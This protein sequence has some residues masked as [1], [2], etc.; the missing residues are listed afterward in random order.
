MLSNYLI[1]III[2][3]A[4]GILIIVVFFYLMITEKRNF[5][6]SLLAIDESYKVFQLQIK[7]DT[8]KELEKI[9]EL[10]YRLDHSRNNL[11][12]GLQIEIEEINQSLTNFYT[13][14]KE[15][16]E[17]VN[18]N[19]N[20]NLNLISNIHNELRIINLNKIFE[21]QVEKGLTEAIQFILFEGEEL[22][23]ETFNKKNISAKNQKNLLLCLI[24]ILKIIKEQPHKWGFIEEDTS[25]VFYL[26]YLPSFNISSKSDLIRKSISSLQNDWSFVQN[27]S[28]NDLYLMHTKAKNI[29]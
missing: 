7:E 22:V 10:E 25:I 24:E 14:F 11:F 5:S 17:I 9:K 3:I 28:N 13:G 6:K 1:Y 18:E 26:K 21:I 8:Q 23:N 12:K 2:L 15:N 27:F 4:L 29:N 19:E 20:N 16:L